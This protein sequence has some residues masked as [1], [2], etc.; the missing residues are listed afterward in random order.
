MPALPILLR[1][2]TW[3]LYRKGIGVGIFSL[4]WRMARA[5]P[6][7]RSIHRIAAARNVNLTPDMV[8]LAL[9]VVEDESIV[10]VIIRM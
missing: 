9:R 10:A 3:P 7:S 5:R 2:R 8:G 4:I 1:A 6:R